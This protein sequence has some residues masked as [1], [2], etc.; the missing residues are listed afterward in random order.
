M[1][2]QASFP[3][4]IQRF[5]DEPDAQIRD[6]AALEHSYASGQYLVT[7]ATP[8]LAEFKAWLTTHRI[9]NKWNDDTLG[10]TLMLVVR[11]GSFA[12]SLLAAI[13]LMVSLVLYWLSVKAK[14]RA[15]RVLAGV[16]T[17]RI[18]YEDLGGFL[19]AMSVVAVICSVVAVIYVGLAHGWVFVPYYAWTLLTFDAIVILITMVCALAMSVASWPS[20]R[21]LANRE[22]AVKSLRKISVVLKA[23]TFALVLATVAPAFT[24]YTDSKEAAVQQAQ[25]KLLA[26]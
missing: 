15:L 20:T 11:Q 3:S 18:Q 2:T 7:G 16:S 21:M 17:W 19:A 26:D 13:A 24:A 5:G 22:P 9:G 14:G 6:S 12:T 8:H 4:T 23:A 10:A 25:W 1:G